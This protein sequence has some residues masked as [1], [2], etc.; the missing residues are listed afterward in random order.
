LNLVLLIAHACNEASRVPGESVR[1]KTLTLSG[2]GLAAWLTGC[3]QN[4]PASPPEGSFYSNFKGLQ[5][6]DQDGQAL[7][8][9]QWQGHLVLVNFV[10]TGCSTVCPVQTAALVE[11]GK[12]LP[13]DLRGRVKRLSVSLDPLHDSA[14]VLKAYAQRLGADQPG[15][16]FATG[17]PEDI[18]RLSSTLALFRPGPDVRRPDDHSTALWLVD[19]AG[20]LR[21]R[22]SGNPPDVDRLVRELGQ[23]DRLGTA[24]PA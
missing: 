3:G 4:T 2:L 21:F 6:H 23:L 20:M 7:H 8:W 22:Y 15:W 12:R 19:A 11:M 5:L 10:Y 18:E 17:R 16:R 14:A 9:Q 13:A 24:P 1:R